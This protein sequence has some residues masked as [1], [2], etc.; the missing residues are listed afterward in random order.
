MRRELLMRRELSSVW[1]I[2]TLLLVAALVAASAS[3]GNANDSFPPISFKLLPIGSY[4]AGDTTVRFLVE[5]RNTSDA[6]V[7][8]GFAAVGGSGHGLVDSVGH[9]YTDAR[10]R[11]ELSARGYA[12]PIIDGDG[13]GCV[14]LQHKYALGPH[15]A[16]GEVV[17]I[18]DFQSN[19]KAYLSRPGPVRLNVRLRVRLLNSDFECIRG[20][21]D[22]VQSAQL[23]VQ[24]R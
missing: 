5:I 17:E 16:F 8:F 19:G 24:V 3:M 21:V 12:D 1:Y 22:V 15:Q 10:V 14:A 7:F 23:Q 6:S 9:V 20:R 18:D 2:R 4:K 11:P 13:T